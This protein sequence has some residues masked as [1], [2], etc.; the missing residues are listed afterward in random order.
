MVYARV[1][2]TTR[3]AFYTGGSRKSYTTTS[4]RHDPK[5]K[6][7]SELHLATNS[8]C[9]SGASFHR[10]P[11][12]EFGLQLSSRSVRTSIE[13]SGSELLL[14]KAQS[15]GVL[16]V[17]GRRSPSSSLCKQGS[18]SLLGGCSTPIRQTITISS[19]PP[20]ATDRYPG[21][22]VLRR[23]R[24]SAAHNFL[25]K[26][27]SSEAADVSPNLSSTWPGPSCFQERFSSSWLPVG[28]SAPSSKT[29]LMRSVTSPAIKQMKLPKSLT[30][31]L[32]CGAVCT[33]PED[34]TGF[35]STI[36]RGV[37]WLS[38][39]QFNVTM[40]QLSGGAVKFTLTH[41]SC[42][43]N[44]LSIYPRGFSTSIGYVVL[45]YC[46]ASSARIVFFSKCNP[47]V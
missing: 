29:F 8:T 40:F 6:G 4:L 41:S 38:M 12:S 47:E 39:S 5:K 19:P 9:A 14:K 30:V 36:F 27:K 33:G 17:S 18:I 15:S 13:C 24:S 11:L 35:V 26:L 32:S 1:L 23:W 42:S 28:S 22:E 46:F 7:L 37:D 2:E 20:C 43:P 34:A 3:T 21:D 16:S 31:L 10:F 44:S 45:S 25:I